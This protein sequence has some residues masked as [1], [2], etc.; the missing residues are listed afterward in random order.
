MTTSEPAH[1]ERG[2]RPMPGDAVRLASPWKW[3]RLATGEIGVIDG[4]VDQYPDNGHAVITFNASTFRDDRVVS[5]S[6]GPATIASDLAT[7][8]PTM[9][10]IKLR[11][12]KWKDGWPGAGNGQSYYVSVPVWEWNPGERA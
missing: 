12:W 3:G 5:S 7:L 9:E 8:T 10:H 2:D 1:V 11:V 4:V 6:G